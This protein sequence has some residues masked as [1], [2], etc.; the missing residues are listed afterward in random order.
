M[1]DRPISTPTGEDRA[2]ANRNA[3]EIEEEK[4]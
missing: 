1:P 4:H 2:E 3:L